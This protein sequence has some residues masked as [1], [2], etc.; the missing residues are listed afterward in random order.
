[1]RE[2]SV[3][4][5]ATSQSGGLYVRP[6]RPPKTPRRQL[7][8]RRQIHVTRAQNRTFLRGGGF[9]RLARESSTF[10]LPLRCQT[11][12]GRHRRHGIEEFDPL[13]ALREELSIEP[14][15]EP[16]L[17]QTKTTYPD[18]KPTQVGQ[19]FRLV[20]W[21]RLQPANWNRL[22]PA[23]WDRSSV[24]AVRP[25]SRTGSPVRPVPPA[26]QPWPPARAQPPAAS[27]RTPHSRGW[28]GGGP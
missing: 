17:E 14:I 18:R 5:R 8:Q 1:M 9:H 26:S 4:P 28:R 19:T 21:A 11:Q 20:R 27:E 12:A 7:R 23:R 13:K 24:S 6:P 2:A 25:S 16:D 10:S 22:P 3:P 15:V